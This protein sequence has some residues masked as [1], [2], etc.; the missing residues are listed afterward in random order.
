[1]DEYSEF[2]QNLIVKKMVPQKENLDRISKTPTLIYLGID[3]S[4]R[5][6]IFFNESRRHGSFYLNS[7][8]ILGWY[9]GGN[10]TFEGRKLINADYEERVK[11]TKKAIKN[12]QI[13]ILLKNRLEDDLFEV[14]NKYKIGNEIAR[15]LEYELRFSK[16]TA[17]R[18]SSTL[19]SWLRFLKQPIIASDCYDV[20]IPFNYEGNTF[21]GCYLNEEGVPKI[22]FLNALDENIDDILEKIVSIDKENFKYVLFISNSNE[23]RLKIIMEIDYVFLRDKINYII[24]PK[25]VK[26][27]IL[28]IK[29]LLKNEYELNRL[30]N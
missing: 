24:V 18:R 1:L 16:S 26:D 23:A 8:E 30:L 11:F 15:F 3:T 5:I 12:S 6:A 28:Y 29:F 25:Y 17:E 10:L 7:C 4:K 22:F 21:E 13:Y 9:G 14:I 20:T 2:K 19:S 27:D